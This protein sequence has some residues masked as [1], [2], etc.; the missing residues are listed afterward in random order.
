M[1]LQTENYDDWE[2]GGS[3]E[4]NMEGDINREIEWERER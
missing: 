3:W 2:G 4:K 1:K